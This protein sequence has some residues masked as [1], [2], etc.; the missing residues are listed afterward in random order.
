MLIINV[1]TDFPAQQQP[2]PNRR[3]CLI[4]LAK[5]LGVL[6]PQIQSHNEE[7]F[8]YKPISINKITIVNLTNEKR[9]VKEVATQQ[10]VM[11]SEAEPDT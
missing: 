11:Y 8:Q 4:T 9:L 1:T 6:K 2:Q 7:A 10:L 3:S 5:S